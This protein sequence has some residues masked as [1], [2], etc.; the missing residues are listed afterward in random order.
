MSAM[1]PEPKSEDRLSEQLR[2]SL[3]EF[4]NSWN[5]VIN[6]VN[7]DEMVMHRGR[8]KSVIEEAAGT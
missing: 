2:D 8:K 4:R 3:S 1:V 5:E 6:S 7:E